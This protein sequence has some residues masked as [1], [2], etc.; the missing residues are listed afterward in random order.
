MNILLRQSSRRLFFIFEKIKMFYNTVVYSLAFS[1]VKPK[2]D[3][4]FGLLLTLTV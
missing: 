4:T 1:S 2:E 3:P